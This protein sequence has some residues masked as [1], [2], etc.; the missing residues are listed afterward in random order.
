MTAIIEV[1]RIFPTTPERLF[2]AWLD[3]DEHARF[4][5]SAASA[6]DD[7]K[8]VAWDGYI[9]AKTL[10]AERPSRIVQSWRTTEFDEEHPDS[11][12][13]LRF[14]E[15][16][17]GTRMT[18]RH[19]ELPPGQADTYAAGWEEYYFAPMSRYFADD[20]TPISA[21]PLFEEDATEPGQPG[22]VQ[23][24]SAEPEPT[25]IV[26]RPS[27]AK[28][29]KRRP[30]RAG[31]AAKKAVAKAPAKKPAG[32]LKAAARPAAKKPAAKKP[33]AKKPAAK[34]SAAKKPAA[35]KSAAKKPAARKSKRTR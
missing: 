16:P 19:S 33:A 32:K 26:T 15:V 13:E 9:Q 21:H 27:R 8:F 20:E 17:E 30:A 7:G 24:E 3:A 2:E 31:S 18:L 11:V 5:G 29:A 10:E 4:T 34:K 22:L 6:E 23:A 12:L 25:E 1:S 35:K 14:E 28:A